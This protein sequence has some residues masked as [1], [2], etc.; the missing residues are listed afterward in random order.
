M[1]ARPRVDGL[2]HLAG[3][4]GPFLLC[5][6]HASHLDAPTL[7]SVLPAAV[8][9]RT[10]IAAAADYFFAGG[11]LGPAV[12]LATGAFPFGRTEH[13]RSS[14]ERV[15]SYVDAGWNVI[16]FPEGTRS[17]T[18]RLGPMKAGI[19]LLATQLDVPVV[20]IGIR[21]ADRILP[22]GATLPR[23]RGRVGVR[24]G[25]PLTFEPDCPVPEAT[26]RIEAAIRGLVGA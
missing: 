24:I 11:L 4:D 3:L 23:W 2:E 14:L 19:G 22:K 10:A 18:G 8:R 13:V 12:A 15:G 21:G 5:P 9:D 7:R 20:P 25:E 6:N 16:V 1:I 26:A 17:T